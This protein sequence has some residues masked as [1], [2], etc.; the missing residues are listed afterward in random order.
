MADDK[1]AKVGA[2]RRSSVIDEAEVR[3]IAAL[4]R[5]DLS[6]DQIAMHAE[7]MSRIVGYIERLQ[8]LDLDGVAPLA[9]PLDAYIE[10]GDDAPRDGLPNAALMKMA[11]EAEQGFVK[12]PKVIGGG[13]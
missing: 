12:V 8:E 11:P 3:R 1:K 4:A 2:E 6:A 13:E 5:L 10:L 7:Q 9:H